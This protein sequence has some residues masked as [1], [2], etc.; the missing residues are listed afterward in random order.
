MNYT[1]FFILLGLLG[2]ASLWI[3]KR[4]G[5]GA[6]T[7]EDYFLAGRGLSLFPL[8]MTLLA[9]QL[10]GGA[11]LGSAEEAYTRGWS[12]F[13]YPLG[14]VL[15]LLFLGLGFGAKMRKLN[16]S[17]VAEIFEKVYGSVP[18]RKVASL[19]SIACLFFVLTANGIASKKLF[20][21]LGIQGNWLYTLFWLTV[22]VYTSFGGLK[23]VVNTDV[24]QAIFILIALS[25][26]G[27]FFF[28]GV[29]SDQVAETIVQTTGDIPWLSWLLMP[30]LF[31]LI[32]Q[33]MGQR[34]FSAKGPRTISIAS[35]IASLLLFGGCLCPIF[36]GSKAAELGITV[37]EGGSVLV[38]AAIAMTNPIV[39]TLLAVAILMAIISTVDSL[40]C[41][42][43]SNLVFDFPLLKK[44][45]I[46][47]AQGITFTLG[48]LTY[49]LSFL[50]DNVL[51]MMIL[52]YELSAALLFV[53]IF[54]ALFMKKGNRRSALFAMLLG[55][56]GFLMLREVPYKEI[57]TLLL[58]ASGYVI[59]A[60]VTKR[61][62]SL[63]KL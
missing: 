36:L 2:I 41:S 19:L 34:C 29:E 22:V 12:V 37:P 63:S 47:F 18:L 53:P 28:F 49:L 38:S 60:I 46:L 23:G 62:E 33:D 21:S 55:A 16:L 58:A 32:G 9:T 43:S 13:F 20:I 11:L 8:A 42:I 48:M 35:V 59:G 54:A 5:R 3:G 61:E 26:V 7:N 50:F 40:L 30:L 45:K 24:M 56:F 51:S 4:A 15:G 10:G 44:R 25:I 1:L 57:W 14:M 31:M 52:S 17:T 39:A 6:K 27:L